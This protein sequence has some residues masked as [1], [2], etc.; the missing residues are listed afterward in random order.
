MDDCI[1][2]AAC[3]ARNEAQPSQPNNAELVSSG[4]VSP[5]L[6][7]TAHRVRRRAGEGG[8]GARGHGQGGRLP[9]APKAHAEDWPLGPRDRCSAHPVGW[10]RGPA[11]PNFFTL[12]VLGRASLLSGLWRTE[13]RI[14]SRT[15]TT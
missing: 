13:S 5:P 1:V 4:V 12:A 10:L 6:V 11:A 14:R 15:V 8:A 3:R 7:P 2:S 9:I